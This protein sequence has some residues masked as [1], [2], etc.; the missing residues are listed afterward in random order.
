MN[1]TLCL[2]VGAGAMV[3]CYQRQNFKIQRNKTNSYRYNHTNKNYFS[4]FFK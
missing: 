4:F 3:A 2:G 1:L